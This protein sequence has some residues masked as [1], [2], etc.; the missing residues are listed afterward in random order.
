M[1]RAPRPDPI[2]GWH[3][4]MNRGVDR[5]AIF[6]D[7]I[8]RTYFLQLIDVVCE[9]FGIEVHSYCLMSN[10]FHLL[11]RCPDA[12]VSRLLHDLTGTYARRFNHRNGRVGH[13]F[14]ARFTSRLV[15]AN[16]YI[17]NAVR[18]IH[19]NPLAIVGVDD[20]AEH[21][22]SSHDV[23][24][25]RRSAPRWL[26]TEHVLGWFDSADSFARHVADDRVPGP[27]VAVQTGDVFAAV[28]LVIAETSTLAGRWLRGQR[29]AVAFGVAEQ[30]DAPD[31]VRQL[32]FPNEAAMRNARWRA[33]RRLGER[34]EDRQ[35]VQRV[36]DL[37]S[38]EPL[39]T[40]LA[41]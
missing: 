16:A 36:V 26:E 30:L 15:T 2:D 3:H 37:V 22:W 14:G 39:R 9:R 17:L 31:I 28:D 13:L 27:A 19:R 40:A 8:D 35:M 5:I 7:D 32:D 25:G 18:Y 21:P 4:V 24:L 12:N 1:S 29:K 38:S 11:I 10:H 20:C 33:R 34:G 23:Y 6:H 41:A